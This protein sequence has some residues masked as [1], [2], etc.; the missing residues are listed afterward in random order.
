[1]TRQ[2]YEW[3]EA[4]EKVARYQASSGPSINPPSRLPPGKAVEI[5]R[6]LLLRSA[7]NDTP[8]S[9]AFISYVVKQ[10]LKD[11]D[12]TFPYDAVHA[13]Y[14]YAAFRTALDEAA[15][16]AIADKPLYRACT[17]SR[18]PIRV[19]DMVCYHRH[20]DWGIKQMQ[21][22]RDLVVEDVMTAGRSRRVRAS[23]CDI[24]VEIAKDRRSVFVV[25]GNVQQSVTVKQLRL[26][27]KSRTLREAQP[28]GCKL[29][30][31]GARLTAA[32]SDGVKR[33]P[34]FAATKC[35]LNDKPWF[36]LL[37]M[38]DDAA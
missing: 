30:G 31:R 16:K 27:P 33:S 1:M 6:E 24:V 7:I 37:Q 22:V 38:R 2:I 3:I 35:S 11:T 5:M 20:E 18:T 23:H 13:G 15:E 25:G 9:A 10:A 29:P 28:D 32:P 19:G 4:Y 34:T 17:P 36:V 12:R 26:D 21:D 8:W 14:I